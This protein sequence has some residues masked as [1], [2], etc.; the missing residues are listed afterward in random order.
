MTLPDSSTLLAAKGETLFGIVGKI[1]TSLQKAAMAAKLDGV[2]LNIPGK[3]NGNAALEVITFDSPEGKD[4]FWHSASHLMAQAVKRLYPDAKFAIGPSIEGGFY[5]D[6]DMKAV[7]SPEDLE[8]IEGEMRKIVEEDIEVRREE[9]SKHDALSL[10]GGA[11]EIYKV[12]LL[13]DMPDGDVSIY[14]QGEFFD[15][16]RGPHV[17]RTSKL[18]AFKL[19]SIAGAYW[20]GDEKRKMLQRIYGTAFPDKKRLDAHLSLLEEARARDHRKLGRELDLFSF[21]NEVGAGLPLWH[22]NGAILRYIIETFSTEEHLK[23]GYKLFSV[24]HIAKAD[25]YRT[26][27]HLD[28]Y[29]ENMYAPIRI[30]EQD[31]YLKPMNCPSQIK[32]FTSSIKSYRDLPFRGFE[33]GTVYRYERSGVLHGL[34]RVRGFTQDDAH[35]FCSEDQIEEEIRHVLDF[36]LY[37]L[38]V[39]GF[40]ERNIYLST[41]PE[42]SVGT[43]TSWEL[44]TSALRNTLDSGGID[45]TVDPGEGVFYGPKIDIKI[46]DALGREWQC[47][48]IQVDFNLPERFDVNYIGRD[49]AKHRPIMIHRAL[50]GSLERFIGILIEHYG[51]KFPV[52]LAPVQ[53]ALINVSE[54]EAD[55]AEGVRQR[56]LD[57]GFRAETDS[58]DESMGY[59][60]RDAINRKVPYIGVIGKKETAG[61]TVSLRKRGDNSSQPIMVEELIEMIRADLE[62]RR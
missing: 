35:I 18:G 40:S 4:V 61:G 25:L 50:L 24:P 52:W 5:Y 51:G 2:A 46:K 16:C 59:R 54:D 23:R 19:L 9:M 43:D 60:V 44:A 32:I 13:E 57:K 49:G 8:R 33:M 14:R 6:I 20:R 31:Y 37:M 17:M 47:S 1:G 34:T 39:F 28:Y 26:S 30:D 15:L 3:V 38:D 48:T 41:R 22:P 10:F 58:R 56:L 12:E 7:I 55:A 62:A 21:S 27:G 45:Y 53:V 11:G 42:D 29:S 36:T